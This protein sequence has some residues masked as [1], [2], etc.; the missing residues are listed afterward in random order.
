MF[1]KTAAS[2]PAAEAV[3]ASANARE[4][5]DRGSLVLGL[6]LVWQ[7]AGAAVGRGA[8]A[9]MFGAPPV[10]G[11]GGKAAASCRIFFGARLAAELLTDPTTARH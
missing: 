1:C 11:M 9:R 6:L 3:R 7:P 2:A 8:T 10:P 5:A 4:S